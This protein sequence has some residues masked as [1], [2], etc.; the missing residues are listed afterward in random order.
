MVVIHLI[1]LILSFIFIL[2]MVTNLCYIELW[3]L[4]SK[5]CLNMVVDKK[6]VFEIFVKSFEKCLCQ[7]LQRKS[8]LQPVVSL[9]KT[10]LQ[11]LS[12]EFCE[13]FQ[14]SFFCKTP[15]VNRFGAAVAQ[16][17]CRNGENVGSIRKF[18]PSRP[19]HL[20]SCIKIKI[21]FSFYCH[22]ALWCFKRFYEG[23]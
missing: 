8:S 14:G 15:L 10:L 13:F 21:N 3:Y 7:S 23:L 4:F 19:V 20:R 22:A 1:N 2:R 17:N 11:M 16:K 12:C 5:I 9:R 6:E 18:N